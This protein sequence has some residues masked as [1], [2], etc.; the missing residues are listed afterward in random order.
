MCVVRT[1]SRLALGVLILPAVLAACRAKEQAP[2]PAT[3]LPPPPS[4]AAVTTTTTST[5][6]SPPPVWGAAHWG[7]T[8]AEVLAAFPGQAQPLPQ[9]VTFGP[10][11]PGASDVAIPAYDIEGAKFRV[12][13]GFEGDALNRVYLSALK[14]AE[15]TCGDLEKQLTDKYRRGGSQR[16]AD[17]RPAT[18]RLEAA[19][20]TIPRLLKGESRISI[21]DADTRRRSEPRRLRAELAEVRE[22]PTGATRRRTA[23]RRSMSSQASS[24]PGRDL[25][26]S[27]SSCARS[28][29]NSPGRVPQPLLDL[30]C[31]RDSGTGT[32]TRSAIHFTIVRSAGWACGAPASPMPIRRHP[33]RVAHHPGA[34]IRPQ[35]RTLSDAGRAAGG[36]RPCPGPGRVFT[37]GRSLA[38]GLSTASRGTRPGLAAGPLRLPPAAPGRRDR[39]AAGRTAVGSRASARRSSPWRPRAGARPGRVGA[40][41]CHRA[42]SL[43]GRSPRG[44]SG[45]SARRARPCPSPRACPRCADRARPSG[46]RS[47]TGMSGWPIPAAS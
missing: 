31:R 3:T 4:T 23:G 11:T 30:R 39:F 10:Q 44:P 29:A 32:G 15:S 35:R 13:F 41:R 18:D 17:Q 33:A 45:P 43:P 28:A 2:P 6:P 14:A 34:D 1:R 9:P 27:A 12:L 26:T 7:M 42:A 24:S 40:R 36:P 47:R 16:R 5:I 8:K 21:G 20:A 25:S 37:L 38:E 22:R 46:D 19:R